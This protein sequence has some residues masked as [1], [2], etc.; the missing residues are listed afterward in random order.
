MREEKRKELDRMLRRNQAKVFLKAAALL[1]P[2]LL[3]LSFFFVWYFDP[4]VPGSSVTG[5]V[6]ALR[7]AQ[8]IQPSPPFFIVELD[9]G[10]TVAVGGT[11]HLV[12]EPGRKVV[13]QAYEG[14]VFG[15][16]TFRFQR[17]TDE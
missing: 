9:S 11:S 13:M 8:S 1:V 14:K 15:K 5:T 16:R 7:Q 2:A 17:Y 3:A 12:F 4:P 10:G 6:V